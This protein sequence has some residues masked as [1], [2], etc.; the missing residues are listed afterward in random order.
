M[1]LLAKY[2]EEQEIEGPAGRT[3]TS[4]KTEIGWRWMAL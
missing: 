3:M 2:L 4:W 1:K